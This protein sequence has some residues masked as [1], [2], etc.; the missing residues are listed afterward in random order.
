MRRLTA[1]YIAWCLVMVGTIGLAIFVA[2]GNTKS[3]IRGTLFFLGFGLYAEYLGYNWYRDNGE[4][5]K[6]IS[7]SFWIPYDRSIL[8]R[9]TWQAF[10]EIAG[11]LAIF[12]GLWLVA[13]FLLI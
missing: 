8:E 3:A 9:M 1:R 7:Q 5:D 4:L 13:I 10:S 2:D 6:L 11:K 12:S